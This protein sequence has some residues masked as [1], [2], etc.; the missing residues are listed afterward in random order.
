VDPIGV[1]QHDEVVLRAVP[2]QE[3]DAHALTLG[4]AQVTHHAIGPA[5][6]G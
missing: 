1:E 6:L 5:D 3:S 4:L 2:F